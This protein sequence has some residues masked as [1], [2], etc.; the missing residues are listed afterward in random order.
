MKHVGGGLEV[1]ERCGVCND[2]GGGGEPGVEAAQ[3]VEDKLRGGYGVANLPKGIGG[4]LELLGV[5]VDR[6]V[7]LGQVVELQLEDDGARLLVRLEQC[8][9]GDVQR[10]G[11]LSRLHGEV[12]DGVVDG[13]IHPAA[14]ASVGLRP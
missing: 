2:V 4:T 7:A 9:D 8:F 14:D 3:E 6:E 11:V 12:E 1:R 13:A 5:G 10:A